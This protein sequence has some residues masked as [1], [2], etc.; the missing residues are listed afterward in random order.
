[1]PFRTSTPPGRY[2]FL[3]LPS[4]FLGGL[5][6]A[7]MNTTLDQAI[8]MSFTKY[9]VRRIVV[10]AAS[11]SITTAAGGIYTGPDK[12]GTPIVAASQIFSALTGSSKWF[13]LPL[14]AP[15]TTDWFSAATLYLSLTTP[16]GSAATLNLMVIGEALD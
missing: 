15:A 2:Q 7:N 5:V 10:Y 13:D 4:V 14:V 1:M 12:S 9:I 6:P 3:L 16:Q 11:V 8:Q